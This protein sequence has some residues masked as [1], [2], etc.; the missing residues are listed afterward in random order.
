MAALTAGFRL[1]VRIVVRL[2][3]LP[4]TLVGICAGLAALAVGGRCRVRAGVIEFHGGAIAWLFERLPVGPIA[5]TFGHTVLGRTAA[6]L[7]QAR[8][9]EL[10]HVRQYERWGPLFVP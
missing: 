6:A 2:W 9:H 10:V 4:W 8:Q 5:M 3:A 1:L 7:D